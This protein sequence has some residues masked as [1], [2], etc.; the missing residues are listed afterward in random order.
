MLPLQV[1][2]YRYHLLAYTLRNGKS[3]K[4]QPSTMIHALFFRWPFFSPYHVGRNLTKLVYSGSFRRQRSQLPREAEN[5]IG[6]LVF[7]SS[8][9]PADIVFGH[10]DDEIKLAFSTKRAKTS[11]LS[12]L[13]NCVV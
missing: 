1:T 8:V 9:A 12:S 10:G 2:T 4:D 3:E 11:A 13:L 5:L 7:R 6:Y